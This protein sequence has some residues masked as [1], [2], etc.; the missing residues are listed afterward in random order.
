MIPV[1]LRQR[2]YGKTRA[3]Q[4][5]WTSLDPILFTDH[6]YNNQIQTPDE[7]LFPQLT[8]QDSLSA[9]T[10]DDGDTWTPG[11]GGGIPS[12]VDHQSVGA[13]P[14]MRLW[15]DTVL[16]ARYLLLLTRHRGF[17]LCA[18]RRW[19]PDLWPG[20]PT[21][22]LTQC[23]SLHGHVK[24]AP[25]GTVYYQTEAVAINKAS[26]SQKT[27]ASLSTF[28]RFR[29]RLPLPTIRQSAIGRGDT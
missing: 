20:V 3:L 11:Q 28:I 16:P 6:G 7:R 25:D 24:M 10:D 13:G 4:I 2:R 15:S 26:W 9:Y 19:R 14:F 5:Q 12:G 22:N 17:F 27:T 21:Y 23:T 18:Q 29:E 1:R 8:G